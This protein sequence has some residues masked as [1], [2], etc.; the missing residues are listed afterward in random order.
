MDTSINSLGIALINDI[1]SLNGLEL[2]AAILALLYV[3][4][5]AKQHIACW[6]C[7]LMSSSLYVVIFWQAQL[8]YQAGLNVFYVVMA[9]YGWASWQRISRRTDQQQ[10]KSLGI[11]WNSVAVLGL[12][13]L[14]VIFLLVQTGVEQFTGLSLAQYLDVSIA[15]FSLFTTWLVVQKYLDNWLY[16]VVINTAAVYLYA[17]Q[18]LY[19]TTVLFGIY[20]LMSLYGFHA[21]RMTIQQQ[22]LNTQENLHEQSLPS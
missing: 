22:Q 15:I 19:F 12:A 1:L 2:A 9:I 21:W 13:L 6:I 4:L 16:W 17:S 3:F 7:A 20:V 18:A 10:V 5:A 14:C 11:L 8:P